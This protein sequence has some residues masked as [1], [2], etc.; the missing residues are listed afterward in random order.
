MV[1]RF[2]LLAFLISAAGLVLSRPFFTLAAGSGGGGAGADGL[3]ELVLDIFPNNPVKPFADGNIMQ[4]IF[5]AVL[6]G[7]ILLILGE[8]CARLQA[9]LSELSDLVTE[10][11]GVVCRLLPLYLFTSLTRQFWAGG[12][13]VL[14]SLGKPLLLFVALCALLLAVK[15]ALTCLRLKVRASVLLRKMFPGMLIGFATGSSAV[16]YTVCT[17][18]NEKK[19]GISP[20]F[21]RMAFPLGSTLNQPSMP[22]LFVLTAFYAAERC[23][24][25]GGLGWFLTLWIVSTLLAYAVPPVAGGTLACLGVLFA[26]LGIPSEALAVAGTLSLFLDMINTGTRIGF[27]HLELTAQADILGALD[28]E[29]L[30][31]L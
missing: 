5:M 1:R 10:I 26:Q 25:G 14:L 28:R 18:A 19:L 24:A 29:I 17:E 11:I 20:G 6:I 13:A 9:V 12:A 22:T 27:L 30:R 2:L 15:T 3:L 4:I 21:N 31:R 23:G 16:A 7:V 8:R